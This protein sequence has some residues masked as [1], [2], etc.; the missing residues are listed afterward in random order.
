MLRDFLR[1]LIEF[2]VPN[3]SSRLLTDRVAHYFLG[4]NCYFIE[5]GAWEPVIHSDTYWLESDHGWEGIQVEPNP[6]YASKLRER[7][8]TTV[9]EAA[10]TPALEVSQP[11]F[12]HGS[13]DSAFVSTVKSNC[14]VKVVDLPSLIRNTGR[15]I[16]ALFMD[17]EGFELPV[18]TEL[19]DTDAIMPFACVET[20]W[21]HAEIVDLMKALGYEEIWRFMSGYNSWFVKVNLLNEKAGMLN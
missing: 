11:H 9:I 10:I 15:G 13:T 19:L 7:R 8:S 12:L 17:I 20:I 5:I 6:M 14:E 3:N 18:L 2:P 4:D 21:N 16:D 1:Y